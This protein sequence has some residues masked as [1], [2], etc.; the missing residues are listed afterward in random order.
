MQ[1]LEKDPRARPVDA[2]RIERDLVAAANVL[3]IQVPP[4][5]EQDPESSRPP[6]PTL[7]A[8]VIEQWLKRVEVFERMYSRAYGPNGPKEQEGTLVE[9]KK[10][11][12]DGSDA[13]TQTAKEQRA[14]EDIDARGRDGRTRFGFAVD[15]L[16]LDASKAKDDARQ[17]RVELD[18]VSEAVRRGKAAYMEALRDVVAWEGRAG[19]QEPYPQLAHAYRVCADAVDSWLGARKQERAAQAV[20]E[21]KDR[22]VSDLDY[23]IAELRA[24]LAHHEQAIDRDRDAGNK[25]VVELNARTER[26]EHQLLL[27]AT[28]FCEPLRARPELGSLFQELESRAVA[29]G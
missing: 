10:L 19:G 24:A 14:L 3:R 18:R 8:V 13:R 15:A 6:A 28:R 23:Q 11:V 7:P 12:R 17:V 1:L 25:R 29:T 21:E 26:I 27:L 5:P 2:H 22:T 9:L 4:E 16:G 20:V